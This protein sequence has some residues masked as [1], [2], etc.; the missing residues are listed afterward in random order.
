MLLHLLGQLMSGQELCLPAP[1]LPKNLS[2][3]QLCFFSD[4]FFSSSPVFILKLPQRVTILCLVQR[5]TFKSPRQD[6]RNQKRGPVLS[7]IS[8]MWDTSSSNE[9]TFQRNL[10]CVLTRPSKDLPTNTMLCAHLPFYSI[11]LYSLNRHYRYV[12]V[13]QQNILSTPSKVNTVKT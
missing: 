7:V 2:P 1:L 11:A 12:A 13:L 8:V 3:M 4:F 6:L 5:T 10:K 9:T